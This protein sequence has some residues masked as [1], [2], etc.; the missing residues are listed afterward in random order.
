[1]GILEHLIVCDEENKTFFHGFSDRDFLKGN[2]IAGNLFYTGS[3]HGTKVPSL[4]SHRQTAKLW[5][6]ARAMHKRMIRQAHRSA[7]TG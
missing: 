7:L 4:S 2:S 5:G 1:M 3:L 6:Y